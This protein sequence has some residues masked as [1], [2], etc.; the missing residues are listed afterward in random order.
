MTARLVIEMEN[1]DVIVVGTQV[2]IKTRKPA[3]G[4]ALTSVTKDYGNNHSVSCIIGR[5][6]GEHGAE[7]FL[8]ALICRFKQD[9]VREGLI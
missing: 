4:E 5:L 7:D 2:E 8:K 6:R 3:K 1:H 9:M